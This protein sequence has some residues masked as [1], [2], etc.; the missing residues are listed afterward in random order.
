MTQDEL[1]EACGQTRTHISRVE[2]GA[3]NPSLETAANLAQAVRL[4]L[5][6]L[7][8]PPEEFERVA[9]QLPAAGSPGSG[10]LQSQ[11]APEETQPLQTSGVL[12]HRQGMLAI[13][14]PESEA[15][16]AATAAANRIGKPLHLIDPAT[17][18]IRAV[19]TS[20]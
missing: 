11:V 8:L 10:H 3:V 13:E 12:P 6:D 20:R 19:I 9:Q 2:A 15:F 18:A 7:L 17:R 14:V 1:A 5:T 4:Q 16:E